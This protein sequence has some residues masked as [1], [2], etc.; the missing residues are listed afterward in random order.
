MYIQ[1]SHLPPFLHP[2]TEW[3]RIQLETKTEAG[4]EPATKKV[5]PGTETETENLMTV[6]ALLSSTSWK[7]DNRYLWDGFL[8]PY[9]GAL[10]QWG[11]GYAWGAVATAFEMVPSWM[12]VIVAGVLMR[13]LV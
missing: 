2:T 10:G 12:L 1:Q 4:T 13:N 5:D 11:G 6:E 3:R 8:H 9:T 7:H